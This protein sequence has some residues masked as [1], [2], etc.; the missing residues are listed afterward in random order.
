MESKV[1]FCLVL[2]S[3]KRSMVLRSPLTTSVD[4][5][6][7]PEWP[8]MNKVWG[9]ARPKGLSEEKEPVTLSSGAGSGS[10]TVSS[11]TVWGLVHEVSSCRVHATHNRQLT[12]RREESG[13]ENDTADEGSQAHYGLGAPY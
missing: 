1:T 11:A 5:N 9:Y 7:S 13:E 6:Q 12:G 8:R 4:V 3:M 10:A 2:F